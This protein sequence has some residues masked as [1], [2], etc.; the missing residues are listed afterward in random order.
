MNAGLAKFVP[1]DLAV[2][3]V[4]DHPL[5]SWTVKVRARP[6]I[7]NEYAGVLEAVLLRV[8]FEDGL[9]IFDAS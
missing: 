9:L 5:E 8:F 2:F 1:D 7:V 6:A 4:V 3:D